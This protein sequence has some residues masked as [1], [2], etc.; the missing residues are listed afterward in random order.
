M[1]ISEKYD[2]TKSDVKI[3]TLQFKTKR[4]VN[5]TLCRPRHSLDS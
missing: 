3:T 4:E 2:K 1:N 5:G